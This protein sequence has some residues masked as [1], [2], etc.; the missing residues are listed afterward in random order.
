MVVIFI[1]ADCAG[2]ST[3]FSAMKSL[4]TAADCEYIH[5]KEGIE[6]MSDVS[7]YLF[8][9]FT[10]D[11]LHIYDRWHYPDNMLYGIYLN[12]E[13]GAL[14]PLR[15][16][17]ENKLVDLDVLYIYV[18]APIEVLE[19]R[20]DERGD[21]L[22]QKSDLANIVEFYEDFLSTTKVNFYRIDT[23]EGTLSENVAN[24]ANIIISYFDLDLEV[25]VDG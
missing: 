19:S 2:K 6:L 4:F 8:K 16:N 25:K 18:E 9:V 24:L 22:I 7:D 17:I 20:Y 1:G 23:S 10:D 11:K 21:D 14:A 5:R 12:D 3:L 15:E 13:P